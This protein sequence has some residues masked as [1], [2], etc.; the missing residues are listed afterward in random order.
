M[1]TWTNWDDFDE[2]ITEAKEFYVIDINE[3][4]WENSTCMCVSN[5][6]DLVCFHVVILA[7]K[8]RINLLKKSFLY[9]T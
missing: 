7:A 4:E 9:N 3:N 8:I 5:S 6:K 2:L 1:T